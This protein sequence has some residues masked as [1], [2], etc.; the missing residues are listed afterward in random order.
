MLTNLPL[1]KKFQAVSLA[2]VLITALV[3]I[4]GLA[5][6]ST[7][8]R[9]VSGIGLFLAIAVAVLAV[10]SIQETFGRLEHVSDAAEEL[11]T[12]RVPMLVEATDDSV[13]F[14]S[15]P[16]DG[17]DDLGRIVG[18]LNTVQAT[19]SGLAGKQHEEIREGLGDLVVNLVRRNQSLLDRQIDHIDQ[20]EAGE[21]D[22]DRLEALFGVDHLATRMRRN[23][24][25]LMVL[26]GAEPPRRKGDPISIN[27]LMRVAM[28][29]IEGYKN[30]HLTKVDDGMIGAQAAFDTAHLLSEL[31]ENATH[32]SPPNAQVELAG[33]SQSDGSYLISIADHGIGMSDD[34]IADTNELLRNP[35]ELNLDLGRSLGFIVVARLAQRMK[36]TV[37][38]AQTPGGA[39]VTALILIPSSLFDTAEAQPG[40]GSTP[41]AAPAQANPAPTGGSAS[42][43]SWS[44]A[45]VEPSSLDLPSLSD[46][47]AWTPPTLPER[48][49]G[50]LGQREAVEDPAAPAQSEALARLLGQTP[51]PDLGETVQAPAEPAAPSTPAPAP[52]PAPAPTPAPAASNDAPPFELPTRE[53]GASGAGTDGG[54]LP[55]FEVTSAESVEEATTAAP[56]K[57][58]EA[59]PTGENFDAGVA[60]LL[61]DGAGS[62]AAAP[63]AGGQAAPATPAPAT[64]ATAPAA[65][66]APATA[67]APAPAGAP[68]ATPTVPPPAT[69][70]T[71]LV[72][73]DR[74]RS[75]APIGEGRV[76]PDQ[77]RAA[78][79]STRDPE[80]IRNMLAR[81]RKA[82]GG[83]S[84]TA[85]DQ[86]PAESSTESGDKS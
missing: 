85:T 14:E 15:F 34:L 76:I 26:A 11:A 25:S 86:T 50:G 48:G 80:E 41:D 30:I 28:S 6:G 20:L 84:P 16:G 42:P 81:Y 75:Q 1:Q 61:D 29:E 57:L 72:K 38:L 69:T 18:A 13:V 74:T 52:A 55:G 23:A 58:E 63:M 68:T 31:L 45:P 19:T 9:V 54:L 4:T 56:E 27:D 47:P 73:R 39:G 82:R 3:A 35:P 24:E 49:S 66:P 32:F 70:A 77:G 83:A 17:E 36:M 65:A 59:I 40:A 64:P 51:N 37:E 79:A 71:G 10:K 43:E 2:S 5:L 46:E 21:E 67:P 62:G 53:V 12:K 7:I 60:S 33:S 22:P 8:V 44:V 78:T